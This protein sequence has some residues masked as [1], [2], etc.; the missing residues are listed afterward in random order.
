MT[1]AEML[2]QSGILTVLGMGVVFSFIVIMIIAMG[3]M[4]KLV[5]ALKL[6]V[7]PAAAPAIAAASV[8]VKDD[9]AVIAAI[10]AA[11]RGKQE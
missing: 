11:L 10:A 9:K 3:L 8:A 7:N 2:G 5:H 1:I 4:K 6:D